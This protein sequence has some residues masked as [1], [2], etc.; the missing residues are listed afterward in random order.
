MKRI[1]HYQTRV[2]NWQR[3][4]AGQ[5]VTTVP[6]Q[7][8]PAF[9]QKQLS[10]VRSEWFDEY[11]PHSIEYSKALIENSQGLLIGT[12]TASDTMLAMARTIE[13]LRIEL[14][15]D[16]ADVAFTLLGLLNACG[17]TLSS[18]LGGVPTWTS[19]ASEEMSLSND[20]REL[21]H[22]PDFRTERTVEAGIWSLIRISDI[23]GFSFFEALEAVCDSNDTKLWLKSEREANM[24]D[25]TARNWTVTRLSGREDRCFRVNGADMKLIK[26]PSFTPPNLKKA[27]FGY[28]MLT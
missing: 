23:I 26:S 28:T 12:Q 17:R 20:I 7:H 19:L 15:D 13:N 6:S 10:Y 11:L 2:F 18:Q 21:E 24:N 1:N 22:G 4:V 14:A 5:P 9:Y 16:V 3:D 8:D 27:V 25:I